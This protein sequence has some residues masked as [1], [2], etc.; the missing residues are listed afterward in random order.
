MSVPKI[1]ID[2]CRRNAPLAAKDLSDDELWDLM[3][4]TYKEY[5][6]GD[7]PI[8]MDKDTR[9]MVL[10]QNL[11]ADNATFV[12]PKDCGFITSLEEDGYTTHL[13]TRSQEH[14]DKWMHKHEHRYDE[15][16]PTSVAETGDI[17]VD[18]KDCYYSITI[19][20]LGEYYFVTVERQYTSVVIEMV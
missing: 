15:A 20:N 8:R 12:C 3:K 9:Y 5:H 13:M 19:N 10:L 18:A 11:C 17:Y 4:D 2:W 1:K 7:T 6:K 14:C 16:A